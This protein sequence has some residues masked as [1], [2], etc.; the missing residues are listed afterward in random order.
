MI[1]RLSI[2]RHIFGSAVSHRQLANRPEGMFTP[3]FAMRPGEQVQVNSTPID[4]MVPAEDGVP[5]RADLTIAVDVATRRICAPWADQPQV[6]RFRVDRSRRIL[7]P[8]SAEALP[9][10]LAHVPDRVGEQLPVVR[11]CHAEG[12]LDEV[13]RLRRGLPEARGPRAD[14]GREVGGVLHRGEVIGSGPVLA[15]QLGRQDRGLVHRSTA[16]SAAPHRGYSHTQPL[17]S[18]PPPAPAIRIRSQSRG[19]GVSNKVG[20]DICRSILHPSSSFERSIS[21]VW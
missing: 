13:Q 14:P 2:G 15:Q 8:P 3:T 12:L 11:A 4:V 5:V 18:R 10:H 6:D 21:L 19:T 7:S 17:R 9:E 1:D 16:S 20:A